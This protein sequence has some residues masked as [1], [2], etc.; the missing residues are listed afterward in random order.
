MTEFTDDDVIAYVKETHEDFIEN[1]YPAD[2]LEQI[3][4][5]KFYDW[6]REVCEGHDF[7]YNPLIKKYFDFENL[8]RDEWNNSA[9][10]GGCEYY[11]VRVDIRGKLQIISS[12][13]F[14][15]FYEDCWVVTIPTH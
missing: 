15:T 3:R 2:L 12:T 14:S 5:V 13:D 9:C 8:L 6:K 11:L 7:K 4:C 1:E 10:C